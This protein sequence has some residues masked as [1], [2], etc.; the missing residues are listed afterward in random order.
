MT[1]RQSLR[2]RT[3]RILPNQ[4]ADDALLDLIGEE[5]ESECDDIDP[6]VYDDL[7][8]NIR[9]DYVD[10]NDIIASAMQYNR[11]IQFIDRNELINLNDVVSTMIKPNVIFPDD[12]PSDPKPLHFF[13]LIYSHQMINNIRKAMNEKYKNLVNES[14]ILDDMDDFDGFSDPL[15]SNPLQ[16]TD[17]VP[18]RTFTTVEITKFTSQDI[19][20]FF[21]CQILM[22]LADLRCEETYFNGDRLIPPL[23]SQLS[24]PLFK[25][26]KRFFTIPDLTR[27][28]DFNRS[29]K[30][31][32]VDNLPRDDSSHKA[33][34]YLLHLNQ[35]LRK[36]YKVG[37]ALSMDESMGLCQSRCRFIVLMKNKPIRKGFKFYLVCCAVTGYC[38]SIILHNQI[39]GTNS[40]SGFTTDIV[41]RSIDNLCVNIKNK[42]VIVDNY[43]G[44][45]PLADQPKAVFEC[46]LVATIR[47]SRIP[48]DVLTEIEITGLKHNNESGTIHMPYEFH[49]VSPGVYISLY[50]SLGVMDHTIKI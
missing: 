30:Y 13:S 49:Q 41:I 16:S 23:I 1:L 37:D 31:F 22:G 42:T 50:L 33:A 2:D 20:K 24:Y 19:Y 44:S 39:R 10:G 14:S 48:T 38:V 29:R 43:Y 8:Y 12:F 11:G 4:V 3:Q 47:S 26:M 21:G 7:D 46:N 34:W 17:A 32:S 9:E 6:E 5:T 45:I 28:D 40:P 25:K 18:N 35:N 36:V 15:N 27:M